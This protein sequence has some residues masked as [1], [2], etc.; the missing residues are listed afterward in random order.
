MAPLI[1]AIFNKVEDEKIKN[2]MKDI[3]WAYVLNAHKEIPGYKDKWK[4]CFVHAYLDSIIYLKLITVEKSETIID[5][6]ENK[7]VIESWEIE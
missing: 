5:Y 6:L 4:R 1:A 2:E 7:G 3:S